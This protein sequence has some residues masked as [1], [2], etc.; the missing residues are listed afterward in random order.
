MVDM[1]LSD[2]LLLLLLLL[3]PSSTH[4]LQGEHHIVSVLTSECMQV[5]YQFSYI[6][7]LSLPPT[8]Y[9]SQNAP[10]VLSTGSNVSNITSLLIRHANRPFR[11]GTVLETLEK[12]LPYAYYYMSCHVR[13]PTKCSLT[14]SCQYG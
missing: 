13:Q 4:H 1:I 5:V 12:A 10:T 6:S 3:I 14:R 7:F 11:C 9:T 8:P 2:L